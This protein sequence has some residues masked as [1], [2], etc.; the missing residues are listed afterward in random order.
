MYFGSPGMVIQKQYQKNYSIII[1]Y[2]QIYVHG[3]F[4]YNVKVKKPK[5]RD[6]SILAVI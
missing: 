6:I 2:F 5:C 4:G 1:E 3:F